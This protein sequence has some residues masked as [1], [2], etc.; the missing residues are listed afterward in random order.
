[1]SNIAILCAQG[2]GDALLMMIAAHNLQKA[3][4]KIT[5]YHKDPKT[6]QVLFPHISCVSYPS[7]DLFESTFQNYD[8]ILLENDNSEK[9]WKLIRLRHDG[10]LNN[11]FCFFPKPNEKITTDQDYTFDQTLSCVLNIQKGCQKIFSLSHV[12]NNNGLSLPKNGKK[13]LYRSRVIL[14]PTSSHVSKNWRKEQFLKLAHALQSN[15]YNPVFVVGAHEYP[16]WQSIQEQGHL[17]ISFPSLDTLALFI[18]ESGYLIGNDSGL[19]HLAS[20]L[21]LPTLTISGSL[22]TIPVWRPGWGL[23]IVKTIPFNLPNWKGIHLRLR[24]NYW[25]YFVPVGKVLKGFNHLVS[26]DNKE[27]ACH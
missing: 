4:Y 20:N 27:Y 12:T 10:A 1:M 13:R 3:G 19:G 25:Q 11:L 2:L 17:V 23:N 6:L 9:A 21:G 15:G 7:L 14:H 18:Y 26:L 22:K 8:A 5:F 24:E 16:E